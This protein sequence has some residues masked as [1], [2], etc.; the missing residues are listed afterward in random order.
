MSEM[1][2]GLA[3]QA[4]LNG[5]EIAEPESVAEDFGSE[6]VVLNSATGVYFSLTDLAA[7]VWRDLMAGQ[8]VYSLI[9]GIGRID[10]QASQATIDFIRNLE[11]AGLIRQR[12]ASAPIASSAESIVL[13]TAGKTA[14]TIQSFDDMKDLILADPIHDVDEE[15]GWPTRR[16]TGDI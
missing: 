6:V 8:P 1:G 3:E 11:A 2:F 5:F 7:A 4:G 9:S 15:M 13:A 16:R 10:R 12:S 14:L